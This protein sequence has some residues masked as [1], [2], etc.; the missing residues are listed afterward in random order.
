[1]FK[2]DGSNVMRFYRGFFEKLY[3]LFW[4]GFRTVVELYIAIIY[5]VQHYYGVLKYLFKPL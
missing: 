5:S 1:M 3:A 2:Y 4:N